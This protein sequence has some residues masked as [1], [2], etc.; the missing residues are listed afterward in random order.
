MT[1]SSKTMGIILIGYRGS[2][3]TTIG[4][5]LAERLHCDFVDTDERIV[6]K[7]GL[8]IREIFE[9]DGEPGFRALETQAL[10]LA[11]KHQNAVISLGGGAILRPQHRQLITASGHSIFY[12]SADP[13][14]LAHRIAADTTTAANRPALTNLGGAEE[15]VRQ[16]LTQREP[17]YR[18]LM[19]HEVPAGK[20]TIDQAV[21]EILR[22]HPAATN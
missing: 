16:V 13:I 6:Q 3:K 12:L 11:L 18:Q 1:L 20:L 5:K 8:T 14:T 7:A 4:R 2:G 21:Q 9:K 19:H 17:L 10:R 22:L 15:E